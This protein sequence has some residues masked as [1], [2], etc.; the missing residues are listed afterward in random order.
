MMHYYATNAGLRHDY[1]PRYKSLAEPGQWR[2]APP[3][4]V[5]LSSERLRT[6]ID[7]TD[8]LLVAW[9]LFCWA[10]ILMRSCGI[11]RTASC[12]RGS[13]A[14]TAAFEQ[15]VAKVIAPRIGAPHG[16]RAVAQACGA[17]A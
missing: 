2:E 8:V 6:T 13:Q 7:Q 15:T 3:D 14:E 17:N 16:A 10:T 1:G 11:S 5:R 4:P 9:A 12:A